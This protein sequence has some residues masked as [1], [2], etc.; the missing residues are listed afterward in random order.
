MK[1]SGYWVSGDAEKIV[2]TPAKFDETDLTE[3]SDW[4][5]AH[6]NVEPALPHGFVRW[7]D[8]VTEMRRRLK[9]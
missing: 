6:Q 3:D 5:K 2:V 9:G 4:T 7:E 8:A 1:F